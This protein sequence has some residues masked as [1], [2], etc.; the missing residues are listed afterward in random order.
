MNSTYRM[1]TVTHEALNT[2]G[3]GAYTSQA[4]V[5]PPSY[6]TAQMPRRRKSFHPAS[7]AQQRLP[8]DL[9]M[10]TSADFAAFL[11]LLQS[12]KFKAL[13]AAQ[14]YV[15]DQYNAFLAKHDV[16][17][18]LPTG[19]G[20]TL[21]ALLIAELWRREGR[22]VAI[23]SANKTLAR[24]MVAEARELRTPAL[25]MEGPGYDI[26]GADK[27]AYQRAHSVAVMNYWVYFNQNPVMDPADLLVMDDAHLAEHCLHSLFS[28]EIDKARHDTLFRSLITELR[29][30]FPEYSVMTDALAS[31]VPSSSPAELLSFLD[32]VEVANRIREIIDASPY[33]KSD[34][35]LSFRWSR[36]RGHLN[37]ANIYVSLTSI[38]IRPYIYPLTANSHYQDVQ[39]RLYVSATIGDPSDLS[40]RLGTKP[41]EKIP[42]PSNLAEQTYGRRLIVMNRIEDEDIPRRLQAVIL[43]ALRIHPKSLWLCS[44]QSEA[45][46]VSQLVL[47]WL[48]NNGIVGHRSWILTS[49]GGE[50]D[51]FKEA[52]QGHLFVGGRFDGMDFSHD[53]CRLVIIKTLP[54]AVNT[55][56]EFISAYL[57]DAG[58]MRKRLNQRIVQGL[59][60]CNRAENDSGVYVL[61]DRRFATH[62]GRESNREGIPPNMIAEIDAAQDNADIG[63][64]E[65]IMKAEAFLRG[66]FTT[67]DQDNQGYR[68]QV[69]K[70]QPVVVPVDTAADEVLGWTALFSSH[71]YAV[72]ADKF[73]A[74]WDS[75]LTT[76]VRE[77]GAFHGWNWAKAL[78]LQSLLGEPDAAARSRAVFERAIG[79]GGASAWF[80][81]MRASLNRS[82]AVQPAALAATDYATVLL[83]ALDDLL[84]RLGTTGDRFERFCKSIDTGL[85]ADSH[86]QFTEALEKLGNTLGY[87]ASRPK[88][89]AAT[90]CR[91]RGVFGNGKELITF[92]VKI[93]HTAQEAIAPVDVGQAHNQISRA[94]AEYGSQGYAIRGTIVTHMNAIEPAADI[95]AATIRVIQRAA[96]MGLWNRARLLLSLYRDQW[97]LDDMASRLSAAERIRPHIPKAGWLIRAL[98]SPERF[99]TPQTLNAEWT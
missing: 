18:E 10:P 75:G 70:V 21:I 32:Q 91:W 87:T 52:R 1:P 9:V 8:L 3:A 30:R 47:K 14:F 78:Y 50:I 25:L 90:D 5:E 34:T 40:R 72:A 69:P 53:E 17:I 49:L 62:F 56:E 82:L 46:K 64:A 88:H 4:G 66:D 96:V 61:A 16:G 2:A 43:A 55:Q 37:E 98:D 44:S 74:C 12:N 51:D 23:L 45:T 65:L 89:K 26:P 48:N 58:F 33:V 94:M 36:I 67:F 27:R 79:R 68:A 31:D 57:R 41:I 80:N 99:V 86:E 20:K 24:Q 15:L 29:A 28:V 6:Q 84:E 83:R 54:R 22:K 97:S 39:Q 63:E 93:A 38:W 7:H 11:T 59:G 71:N 95:S 77:M 76:N 35:D 60:R 13:R 73:E 19:A 92:E 81:R 85:Q 42:V